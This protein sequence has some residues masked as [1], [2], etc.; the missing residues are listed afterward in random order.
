M[1]PSALALAAQNAGDG[2][3]AEAGPYKLTLDQPML[4]P[5]MTFASSRSLRETV[6]KANLV[7][8]PLSPPA[9]FRPSVPPSLPACLPLYL[10]LCVADQGVRAQ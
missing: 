9:S 7:F 1:P 6:Y 5:V 10:T 2:A 3:T 4:V 8:L